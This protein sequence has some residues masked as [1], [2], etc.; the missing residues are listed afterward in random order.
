MSTHPLAIS[1]CKFARLLAVVSVILFAPAT[2]RAGSVTISWNANP[3]A[4]V[5]GYVVLYG[6]QSGVYAFSQPVGNVTTATV[7]NLKDGQ[8]YY[9]AVR[10]I[11][12][13]GLN[14]PISEEISSAVSLTSPSGETLEQWKARFRIDDMNADPDGDSV[15]NMDEFLNGTDPF[16]PNTWLLAEGATGNFRT[17]LALTN[18]GTDPAEITVRFLPQGATPIVQQYSIP[19]QSRRTIVVND[20]AGLQNLQVAAEVTTQ[21][22]GVLVERTV[23]WGGP[24]MMDSAHTGKAVD[25]AQ[26]AWYFAEGDTGVFDTYLAL[27][28]AGSADASATV[29]FFLASG[30]TVQASYVVPANGRQS[31]YLNTVPG[32]SQTS[33]GMSVQAT[34]PIAAERT[35]YFNTKD[36]AFKGGHESSGVAEPSRKWFLAEGQTGDVFAEYLLLANP[37]TWPATATVNY[38]TP[39]GTSVTKKYQLPPTSRMTVTVNDETGLENTEVSA[40]ITATMP[41]VAERSMYWPG[42]WGQWEEG[43]NSAAMPALGTKWALSEGETGG[44]HNVVSRFLLVNPNSQDAA[45]TLTL[46]RDNSLAPVV[47]RATVKANSR[48]TLSSAEFPLQWGEQFGT[49]VESTNGVSF[50]VERSMYWDGEGKT[51]IAGTNETGTL[52]RAAQPEPVGKQGPG[53]PKTKSGATV[54]SK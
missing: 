13:D 31:I 14:S 5:V 40:V 11:N 24:E 47:V 41:I 30:Q 22:G 16:I 42:R 23:T 54:K 9:F 19:G 17:R 4:D 48:M 2:L 53:T 49:V 43:H 29:T 35:M 21:R 28:N 12:K 36:A 26:T 46:L 27:A 25:S 3:E 8:T 6:T 45:V 52:I 20:I 32:L 38:L 51:W 1:L 37:N 39:S 7:T 10:A 50:A 33:F 15:T 34:A 44:A 18:P